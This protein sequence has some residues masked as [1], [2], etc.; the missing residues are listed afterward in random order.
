LSGADRPEGAGPSEPEKR[1]PVL[2]GW[3]WAIVAASATVLALLASASFALTVA[4][5]TLAVVAAALTIRAAVGPRPKSR[6]TATE[7]A[8]VPLDSIREA[9]RAGTVGREDLVFLLDRLE[10]TSLHPTLPVRQAVE[11]R[12]IVGVPEEEFLRYL[13]ERIGEFEGS[14]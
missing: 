7:L 5:A 11:V 9:F 14:L 1:R 8:P 6:D 12:T 2:P 4:G 13:E 3:G 10:R